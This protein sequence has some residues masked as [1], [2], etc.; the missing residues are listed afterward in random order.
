MTGMIRVTAA[1]NRVRCA[2]PRDCAEECVSLLASLPCGDGCESDIILFPSLALCSPACESLFRQPLLSERCAAALDDVRAATAG[3]RGYVIA[4]FAAH[5]GGAPISLV[6]VLHG[7]KILG[8]VPALDAPAPLVAESD[9]TRIADVSVAVNGNG[10]VAAV[11]LL[12]ADTL[13]GVGDLRFCVA[14]C[15]HGDMGAMARCLPALAKTG[16]DLILV[17]TY[18]PAYAGRDSEAVALLESLSRGLGVGVVVCCGGVGDTSHPFVYR[19]MAVF[20]ECGEKLAALQCAGESDS[21]TADFDVDVIHAC[22]RYFAAARPAA[23][24]PAY[25]NRPEPLRKWNPLPFVPEGAGA[26]ALLTEI[27]GLAVRAL[28]AR[29][30]NVGLAR[31]VIGVSG[32]L[33]SAVALLICAGAVDLLGLGRESIVGVTMP[34]F[35]T[36]DQT[37]F[38]ALSLMEALS[39]TKRDISIREAV[40]QHLQDIGHGARRD[41]VYE[42]AQAR[43]RAQIL[44]DLANAQAGLVVGTGDMSEAAL[45]FTTFAGDHIAGYN[46]NS[47]FPKTLL[48]ALA[49]HIAENGLVAGVAGHI[50]AVLDL[51][52]SPELLPPEDGEIAQRTEELLGPYKLHDFFLYHFLRHRM[53]PAKLYACAK[54]VFAGE[55]APSFIAEKLRLFLTRFCAAQFKRSCAPDAAALMPVNLLGVSFSMPSDLDPAVLLEDLDS[56]E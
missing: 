43:E 4:G 56:A 9:V 2:N 7:G 26:G 24:I 46:V 25:D 20:F 44:L 1:V 50:R 5:A 18:A 27:Y 13:F 11:P 8:L 54:T 15:G 42:N 39:V 48:R 47:C 6:A 16:C 23:S 40:T 49:A 12:P 21:V 32:G 37:Y 14:A 52:V 30:E 38:N 17:P 34:G 45:G 41:I 51:P 53:R 35:G 31:L 19:G 36:G 33:D 10:E 3:H 22:R 28:A 29:M 55:F